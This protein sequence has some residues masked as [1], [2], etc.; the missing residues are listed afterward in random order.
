MECLPSRLP[1]L[2]LSIPIPDIKS[3]D[4]QFLTAAV[5]RAIP[6]LVPYV[7]SFSTIGI[8]WLNHHSTFN[9]VEK[10]KHTTLTLNLLLLLI[11]AFYTLSHGSDRQVWRSAIRRGALRSDVHR[12]RSCVQCIVARYPEKP[13]KP[14][15]QKRGAHSVDNSAK[16]GWASNL[17]C[18][19][20][21]RFHGAQ[22]Q[23]RNFLWTCCF[24]LPPAA[25]NRAGA[26]NH[27][28]LTEA[29]DGPPAGVLQILRKK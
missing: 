15:A 16:F 14:Q 1:L 18:G 17:S 20:G 6:Q 7:T 26:G 3:A 2:V 13:V 22:D 28:S 10:V 8:I 25:C 9:E 29:E 11:I 5:L 27:E 12:R 4:D 24:L 23:F 21:P 19:N